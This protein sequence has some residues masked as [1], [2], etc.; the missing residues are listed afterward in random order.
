MLEETK[1]KGKAYANRKAEYL[2]P[3]GDLYHSPKSIFWKLMENEKIEGITWECASGD[4]ALLEEF[5]KYNIEGFGTD[6]STGFD[7]LKDKQEKPFDTILTN[8]PFSLFDSFIMKAKEYD[9]D[10]I[11]M[12]GKTNFLGVFSRNVKP[13]DRVK[14]LKE[15][16]G[17]ADRIWD[18][19]KYMYVFDRMI[20]Y[21]TPK[22]DDG[23]FHVGN[24]VTCWFVW[25]KGYT[26]DPS[27]KVLEVQDYATLGCYKEELYK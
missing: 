14:K 11:I 8:P 6:L 18:G 19:L 17:D 13:E 15:K 9:P 2:R 7:F 12:L 16:Y 26:G 21:Q 27:F 10:T 1:K 3:K 20:D 5:P 24:L 23:Y 22:R 4:N 25:K